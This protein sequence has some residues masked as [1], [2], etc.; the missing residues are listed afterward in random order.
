MIDELNQSSNDTFALL[1]W[2]KNEIKVSTTIV[3]NSGKSNSSLRGS[4]NDVDKYIDFEWD[5]K[6]PTKEVTAYNFF[7]S[8]N[9]FTSRL[10]QFI[11]KKPRAKRYDKN[12]I[13]IL[14]IIRNV[15]KAKL[16]SKQVQS[17]LE[18]VPRP[19]EVIV[20]NSGSDAIDLAYENPFF[21]MVFI[22][23]ALGSA[24]GDV[25]IVEVLQHL[26]Y[27]DSTKDSIIIGLTTNAN[28]NHDYLVKNGTDFVWSL[29]LPNNDTL[30]NKLKKFI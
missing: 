29:P 10:L 11:H 18:K 27:A 17:A 15:S 23:N 30:G 4:Q 1:S 21:N 12:N 5:N 24:V 9:P 22:D 26:Q 19:L 6:L 2:L 28:T 7:C 16:I 14:L 25:N 3:F 13:K 8:R 20:V